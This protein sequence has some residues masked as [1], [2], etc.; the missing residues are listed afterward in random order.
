MILMLLVSILIFASATGSQTLAHARPAQEPRA[1]VVPFRVA[2]MPVTINTA[3][4]EN[5]STDSW[6][7]YSITNKSQ[8]RIAR[9]ELQVFIIDGKGNVESIEEGSSG[10]G[11]NPGTTQQDEAQ[12]AKPI[13]HNAT[14]IVAL[15]KA[16]G[17]SGLWTVDLSELKRA[18]AYKISGG[19]DGTV[20]VTYEPHTNV[21]GIDR[22][23]IFE[24]LLGNL[25]SD[26]NKAERLKDPKN[27]LV[28]SEN[29]DFDL[30]RIQDVNLAKLDKEEIQR[31]AD[32]RGRVFYLIYR[33]LRIEGARVLARVS[34]R[35]ERARRPGASVPYKFT[36]LFTCIKKDGRW[37]I[38]KSLGYAES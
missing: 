33:P 20:K 27:I 7:T 24:L 21:S 29:V 9:V 23:E 12:I 3:V 30:P 15:T 18:V 38:E 2:E 34:I 8:E 25:L 37:T 6:L 28:L 26:A 19:G 32:E 5:S 31:I 11:I 35:D 1:T 13:L 14:S 36:Y 16:V 10:E 4:A 17:Q 22:A